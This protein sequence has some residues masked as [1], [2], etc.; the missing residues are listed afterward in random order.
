MV[1]VPCGGGSQTPSGQSPLAQ[2]VSTRQNSPS[3]HGEQPPP[4]S[5]AVSA[6]FFTPSMQVGVEH[7]P[8][9]QTPLRQSA[10]TRQGSRSLHF[11]MQLPPQSVAVSAPFMT[12][13][14]QV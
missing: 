9:A 1:H 2:S 13:S 5:V 11:S 6:P 14:E 10:A 8:A 12:P 3:A 7:A 4:Q